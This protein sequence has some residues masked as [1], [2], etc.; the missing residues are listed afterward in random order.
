LKR[1]TAF[2]VI[3]GAVIGAIPPAVGWVAGNGT[4]LSSELLI[5]AFFFFIWQVPHFWLLL[6]KYGDDYDKAGYP[7]LTKLF[8]HNQIRRITFIWILATAVTSLLLAF[9]GIISSK[10]IILLLFL[11]CIVM[12][13]SFRGLLKHNQEQ[14]H[15]RSSFMRINIFFLI[16]VIFIWIENL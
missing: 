15:I 9:Y 5:I 6:L 7:S 2:A 11:T 14:I 4:L 13:W 16:V 1:R 10:T 8:S 3:P 12:V